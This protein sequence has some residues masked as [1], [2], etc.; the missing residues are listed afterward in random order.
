M[1][2][3]AFNSI[4]GF[5]V[6]ASP[7]Q[8]II[9]A[10]GD[11]TTVNFTANGVSSL[12][13]ISNVKITGGTNGQIVQTDG[14]GNLTFVNPAVSDSAAPMPYIIPVGETYYVPANFQGLFTVPITIDGTFEVD[15]ILAEVG[16]AINSLNSQIIFD[17]NGQLT[18]NAGFTF[19]TFTGN[20]AVPGTGT[21]GGSLLP[22][23]NITYDLGSPTKRWKDLYLA[24]NTIY[25]G[26][27]TI[28]TS[29][30]NLVFT[31]GAGGQVVVQGNSITTSNQIVNQNSNLTVNPT[32]VLI[33][34]NAVDNV[35]V[36][37]TT[38]ST[39]TGNISATGNAIVNGIL[40]DNYYYANGQPI[41]TQNPSGSNTQIQYNLN[42]NFGASANFT[43]NESTNIL[44]VNGNGNFN[45]VSGGNTVSANYLIS[46]SGCVTISTG[47]ISV[48][49]SNAGIFN[50]AISNINLGLAANVTI[51]S[52]S[53]QV[54]IRNNL[55]ANGNVTV[56]NTLNSSN[57]KVGDLYSS[58]V[59]VN[60]DTDTVIDTFDKTMF[61]SA[62]YTIKAG[63]D[64]GYQAL[65]VL[66][67][68]DNIN[69]IITVY[70]SLST[71][72]VDLIV[73]T[74]NVNA[75]NIELLATAL[76]ANTAVNLMGTYVPD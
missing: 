63:S 58:R 24:N 15:G 48:S 30:A 71:A 37:T 9:L 59:P 12:G 56:Q 22:S 40:T 67:I 38:G 17:D 60:V 51:G 13:P 4:Q 25:I 61:R 16:T 65:E 44:T 1:S 33:S 7:N 39:I 10:N 66:L 46:T 45:N 36:F 73:L 42:N 8:N 53:G 35:A 68:H 5:S 34:V 43:F 70:G 41:D 28:S 55:Y 6:G 18:G 2:L 32:N 76:G 69:S 31:N 3:K 21:F 29:G 54:T 47:A 14:S 50:S 27:S 49:G 52:T 11:I 26:T 74:S 23:A 57:I 75:G 62:K 72:G 64:F 20:L 19:D